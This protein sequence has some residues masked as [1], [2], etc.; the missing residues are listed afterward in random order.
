MLFSFFT[1]MRLNACMLT[2]DWT[3]SKK[4]SSE[5]EMSNLIIS[6]EKI[7]VEGMIVL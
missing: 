2:G 6:Y 4:L 1:I 3:L 7:S 5:T